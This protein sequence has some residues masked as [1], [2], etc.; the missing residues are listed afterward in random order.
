MKTMDKLKNKVTNKK[1]M[2]TFLLGIL[3]IGIL[4]GSLFIVML[5]S[6]DKTMIKDYLEQF[7]NSVQSHKLNYGQALMSSLGT[8]LFF[9]IMIWLLGIS[10][11]GLPIMI[12]FYFSKAF[13]LGFSVSSIIYQYKLK[14]CL[15]AF[16]YVF[17]HHI[18]NILIYT[19]LM[20]Y[21]TRLSLHISKMLLAKKT[22]D[23]KRIMTR[24]SMVLLISVI[25]VSVTSLFEVFVMPT[26][27]EFI[28][29]I[30]K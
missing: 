9:V 16:F 17:P 6:S 20:L 29:P 8:N 2:L 5:N 11:I 13:I 12:F 21:S 3:L 30:I 27:I 10:V 15:L 18:G 22:L 14:G 4:A 24:Y 26:C 1:K 7:T 23:F 25:G 28:L 19:F